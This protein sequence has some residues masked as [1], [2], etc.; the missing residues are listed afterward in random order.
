[1]NTV[2]TSTRL[3]GFVAAGIF[4]ALACSFAVAGTAADRSES[5]GRVIQYGDLNLANPQGAATLY[6]RIVAAAHEVC[7][8]YGDRSLQSQMAAKNCVHESVVDAVT[9]VGR[10]QLIAIYNAKNRQPLPVTLAASLGR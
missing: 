7:D 3:R 10:S 2:T 5:Q 8:S 9:K 6:S 4:S 1:M